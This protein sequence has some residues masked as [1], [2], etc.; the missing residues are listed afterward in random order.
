[1]EYKSIDDIYAANAK[2]R[3]RLRE[4]VA[5]IPDDV[6]TARPEGEKWSVAEIVE[7]IAKVNN[8]THRI[9]ERL[10]QKAAKAD[11]QIEV[12][13]SDNFRQK[14]SEIAAMKVEA[15]EIV[16]PTGAAAISESLKNLDE[17]ESKFA[18]LRPS[19]EEIDGS[20]LTFPHPFFGDITAHEW[21]ILSGGHEARHLKQIEMV[22]SLV[23]K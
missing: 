1:M 13:M 9:C 14:S 12:S 17:L 5:S 6:A 21:L 8:G 20:S 16:R 15:P 11:G 23:E 7:H 2:V 4:T 22:L 19:F 10:L 18:E 3:E